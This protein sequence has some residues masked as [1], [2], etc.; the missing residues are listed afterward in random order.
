MRDKEGFYNEIKETTNS[1]LDDRELS[2]PPDFLYNWILGNV[3]ENYAVFPKHIS[4]DNSQAYR[5]F[6]IILQ[7]ARVDPSTKEMDIPVESIL[8]HLA[9]EGWIIIPPK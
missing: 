3:L 5:F 8:Q 2:H 1:Y 7:W 6:D 4:V 9:S